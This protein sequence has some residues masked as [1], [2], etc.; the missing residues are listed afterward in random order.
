MPEKINEYE[1][2]PQVRAKVLVAFFNSFYL[3]TK[4]DVVFIYSFLDSVKLSSLPLE[5]KV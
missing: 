3:L 2:L 5:G 4:S 1:K